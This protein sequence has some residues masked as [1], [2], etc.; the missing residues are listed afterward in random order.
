MYNTGPR[1]WRGSFPKPEK[2][3]KTAPQ[4]L[5]RKPKTKKVT[6]EVP[7]AQ[8]FS[9]IK[10]KPYRATG[11]KIVFEMIWEERPHICQVTGDPIH[12][13]DVWCFMHILSK[14]AY[15][16]FK[17]RKDNILLVAKYVHTEYDDGD[18]SSHM[19]DEVNMMAEKLKLEYYGK[20]KNILNR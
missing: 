15:P 12:T 18:R 6:H 1:K 20:S 3:E 16:K 9:T 8:P 2:K 10:K 7:G 13:F 5:S 14:G 19:F 4:P 17:L 11:E